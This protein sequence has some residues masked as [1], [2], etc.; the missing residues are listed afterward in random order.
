MRNNSLLGEA[1]KKTL[2]KSLK[3]HVHEKLIIGER[4]PQ[5]FYLSIID[6]ITKISLQLINILNKAPKFLSPV[7]GLSMLNLDLHLPFYFV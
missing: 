6:Y 5:T 4:R 7:C 2:R 1:L 3:K